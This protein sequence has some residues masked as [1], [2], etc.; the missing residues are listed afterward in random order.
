[1]N[2]LYPLFLCRNSN[3]ELTQIADHEYGE[4]IL[5]HAFELQ[6]LGHKELLEEINEKEVP[7]ILKR[8]KQAKKQT[9]P[10][11]YMCIVEH[12]VSVIRLQVDIYLFR[13]LKL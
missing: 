4:T 5:Y 13:H 6:N 2:I 9:G 11:K 8:L 10:R 3:P 1:M 7:N 12:S